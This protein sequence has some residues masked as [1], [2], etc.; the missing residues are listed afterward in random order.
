M[1]IN[2]YNNIEILIVAIIR[3]SP[4]NITIYSSKRI[5]ILAY[6]NVIVLITRLE[7]ILKLLNNRDLLF[8]LKTLNTLF[9]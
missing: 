3:E 2:V 4:I 9:I 6:F 1:K 7:K 5:T 8:K